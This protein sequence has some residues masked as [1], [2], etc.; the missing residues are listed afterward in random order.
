M[1]IITK[2]NVQECPL[3]P[4]PTKFESDIDKHFHKQINGSYTS[5]SDCKN[6]VEETN[7][8][9]YFLLIKNSLFYNCCFVVKDDETRFYRQKIVVMSFTNKTSS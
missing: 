7:N 8:Q 3:Y 6:I 9:F 5:T 2:K 4:Y 1:D